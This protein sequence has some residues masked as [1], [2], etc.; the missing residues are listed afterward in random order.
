M[1]QVPEASPQAVAMVASEVVTGL[2]FGWLA[3]V[4]ALALP[5]AAQFIAYLMGL[6]SVLQPDPT[7]GP[8]TTALAGLANITAPLILL[9]SG[10]YA[11]PL[12][13]L[14]GL[15]QLIP[16]GTP[17]PAS[18][19]ADLAV[20]VVTQAFALSVRLASPFIVAGIIWHVTIGL[21]ARL[22]PRI[23]IYF[24]SMPGQI[25]G[26]HS[27]PCQPGQCNPGRVAGWRT[28]GIRDIARCRLNGGGR[29]TARR[30]HRGCHP[31]TRS[32]CSRTGPC[33][34]LPRTRHAGGSCR[35]DH[36]SCLRRPSNGNGPRVP[37][38]CVP[39]PYRLIDPG[40]TGWSTPRDRGS[41]AWYRPFCPGGARWRRR[42]GSAANRR[43]AKPRSITPHLGHISPRAGIRRLFGSEHLAEA[44]KSLIKL[45]AVGLTVWWVLA[46][47]LLVLNRGP[48][49]PHLLLAQV[50]PPALH[51]LLI[52]L[53][54]QAIIAGMDVLLV[55]LRHARQL[56]MSR[57]DLRDEQRET[58]GDPKIKA[59][60]RQI[61]MQR[62]G[63]RM[64]A[65]V[66]RATVV[67]TNPTSLCCRVDIRSSEERRTAC[68]GERSRLDGCSDLREAAEANRVPVV[69]N[70]PLA[71]ALYLVDLDRDIPAEHYQ[72]VAEIIAYVWR[73]G[74]RARHRPAGSL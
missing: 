23:Q 13:A 62:S 71:R 4:T 28:R 42:R 24:V 51:L 6:T 73:L 69:A 55:R 20:H 74:Q 37:A 15:Y 36:G 30:S 40:W 33:P 46:S 34:N 14:S 7:L 72:A 41:G 39:G 44:G 50:M 54:A 1:P 17:L 49:Y 64:L 32:T 19:S 66:P 2:W 63:R 27:A 26:G 48:F 61:R 18:S 3:R 65:A 59:R 22:V 45:G 10:L 29:S 5:A 9:V 68:R 58:D 52:A 47:D 60:I 16:P 67:V 35:R 31:P 12:E 21:I 53:T 8:Q 11:L 25:L 56:R 57:Q 38:E 70:P 43:S